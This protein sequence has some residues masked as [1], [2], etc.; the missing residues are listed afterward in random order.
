[1]I[2]RCS[3]FFG[4]IKS[5]GNKNHA[6]NMNVRVRDGDE[7]IELWMRRACRVGTLRLNDRQYQRR[8][9]GCCV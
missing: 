1:M 2:P 3:A 6:L 5:G 8:K 9:S 7:R 4:E